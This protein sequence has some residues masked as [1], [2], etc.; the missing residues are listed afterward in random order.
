MAA[1]RVPLELTFASKPGKDEF[2][3]RLTE[4]GRGSHEGFDMTDLAIVLVAAG[5]GARFG[6]DGPKQYAPLAGKSVLAH[7][8][9]RAASGG[10]ADA[11]LTVIHADDVAQYTEA[12]RLSGVAPARL[13]MAKGGA[14][15]QASVRQ[16][17]E[18]LAA[19]G[20]PADGL[21]L[22]HDAARPLLD[23]AVI[24]RAAFAAMKTG[25][26][27]PVLPVADTLATLDAE[28]ALAS[29][30]DRA[31]M[32]L[33]QTPQ[34]FRFGEILTAH[35]AAPHE[36]FTDDAGVARAA[37]MFVG[38]FAG[39]A[40]LFKITVQSD[41]ARA[42]A[43]LA[44]TMRWRTGMGYD[45]HAFTEG[46]AVVLGGVSIP[47]TH[48]LLGHSDADPLL[49]AITDALLGAIGEADIGQHFPPA[50]PQWKG[51]PSR[52]FVA[53]AVELVR[54]KGGVIENIDGT[55]IAEAPKVG[56]HRAAMQALIAEVTGLPLDA[57]GIKATTNEKIGFVGRREG[58]AA[59]AVAT[60]RLP[61]R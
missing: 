12:A 36:N 27:I 41:L 11:V 20:F 26:A 18:A 7:A 54:A 32:R 35:R 13:A 38:S 51:A 60:I 2:R 3:N 14:T 47:H 58:I 57:I 19:R 46:D 43:M 31:A 22:I 17:L 59:M 39:S 50:D 42:E 25:A 56:P 53:K 28:G 6:G 44:G 9:A 37:G 29:N 15:R 45:V 10:H 40:D 5:R 33:V 52:I 24:L 30:P 4:R 48:R 8:L 21:V 49:H 34:A 23:E 16:G 1:C 55:I 61:V